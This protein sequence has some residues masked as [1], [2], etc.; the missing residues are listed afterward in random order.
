M[1]PVKQHRLHSMI[2]VWC[3]ECKAVYYTCRT[4]LAIEM[5]KNIQRGDFFPTRCPICGRD[6]Y[7]QLYDVLLDNDI[8]SEAKK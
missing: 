4:D 2:K 1:K 6:G 8:H 7:S 5:P 3:D